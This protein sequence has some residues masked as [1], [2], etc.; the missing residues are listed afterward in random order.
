[1]LDRLLSY[2]APHHCYMCGLAGTL[3]CDNCKIYIIKRR[4]TGCVVCGRTKQTCR[5][6]GQDW[7]DVL[8]YCGFERCGAVRQLI[9]DYKFHRVVAADGLLAEL[10]DKALPGL[11]ENTVLIPVPTAPANVRR[12]GYDHMRRVALKLA[13]RRHLPCQGLIRRR[14]NV[15]QHFAKTAQQR[16][17]QAQQFFMLYGKV[18]PD[19]TYLIIDDIFTTGSTLQAAVDI[20][21]SAGAE[22]VRAAVI[23]RHIGKL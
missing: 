11:P 19:V 18:S 1:M 4:F 6:R 12:R 14:S 23:A 7:R 3:L 2:L 5:C 8:L 15:T 13:K 17:R 22:D 16:R 10:L 9:D 20:L 21:K